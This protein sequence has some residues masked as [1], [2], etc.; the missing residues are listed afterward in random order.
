[1]V[2]IP[3]TEAVRR[4]SENIA[5]MDSDDLREVYNELFPSDP[6]SRHQIAEGMEPFVKRIHEHIA[7]GLELEEIVDLW[8][9]VFPELR[10]PS[11]GDDTDTIQFLERTMQY[12]E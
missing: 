3:K 8:R 10:K 7:K 6:M 11:F 4:L 5:S 1:M 2:T 9:V 12:T